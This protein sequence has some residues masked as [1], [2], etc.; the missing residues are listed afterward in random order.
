MEPQGLRSRTGGVML[1]PQG[2][3]TAAQFICSGLAGTS[4]TLLLPSDGTVELTS[5]NNKMVVQ[6]FSSSPAIDPNLL[7]VRIARGTL[8]GG[9]QPFSIGATLMVNPAQAPGNYTGSFDVVF[10]FE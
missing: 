9:S 1:I 5:G 10:N 7:P 2:I 6:A 3:G 8:K 4:Y